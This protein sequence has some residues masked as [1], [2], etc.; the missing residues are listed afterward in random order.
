MMLEKPKAD[1]ATESLLPEN[2]REKDLERRLAMLGHSETSNDDNNVQDKVASSDLLSFDGLT[3]HDSTT[4]TTAPAPAPAPLTHTV[5]P[6]KNALLAKI[7]AAQERAK[8]VQMKQASS[9]TA[10]PVAATA[11][12]AVPTSAPIEQKNFTMLPEPNQ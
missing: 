9:T 2:D 11:A 3:V 1:G 8:Q 5:K 12:A 7:M 6:N 10:T 4:A